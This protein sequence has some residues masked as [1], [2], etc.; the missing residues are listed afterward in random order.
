MTADR[1]NVLL[2]ISDQHNYRYFSHRKRGEPVH[3]PTLD[4]LAES[5]TVF[6]RTY[7]PVPLCGPS[8]LCFLTGREARNAGG[9]RNYSLLKPGLETVAEVLSKAG[10]ET[11]LQGKMH[12]GGDRQFAGFDHRPYGDLTGKGG[13]QADPPAAGLD[14]GKRGTSRIRDTG[15]TG[16]PESHLQETNAIHETVS[17]LREHRHANPDQP[18]FVTVS[19]SRPHWPRTAPSRHID[20]YAAD[21]VPEPRVGSTD[22]DDHPYVEAMRERYALDDIDPADKEQA[23]AA[24]FACVDF[25]DEIVGDLLGTLER[26][27]TLDETIV[28]YMSDHGELAGE[29]GLWEKRTWHEGSIRVPLFVQLPD[30]RSGV[31]ASAQI[32][33]PVSLIDLFPTICGLTGVPVPEGVDG[34]DLST[35]VRDGTEPDRDSVFCDYLKPAVGG[36]RYRIAIDDHLK[37][38]R[39]QDAPDRLFDLAADPLERRNLLAQEEPPAAAD[40]LRDRIDETMDFEAAADAAERDLEAA[41]EHRLGVPSGTGNTYYLP[42]GRIV[43]ADSILYQPHVLVED[44]AVVFEDHPRS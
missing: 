31:G 2:L 12:L 25:L 1:P 10:Y 24:Y 14:T 7:C 8:R 28:I 29:H 26:D 43:D 33:T 27:G 11:C 9:W 20:R 39:F 16:I 30:Q 22:A 32:E 6:D 37:Y 42:D 21:S 36:L 3:T 40:R 44:P 38:V 23:R 5:G 13:H 19:F 34:T 35:A 41:D 17:W 4:A 15:V 18:W